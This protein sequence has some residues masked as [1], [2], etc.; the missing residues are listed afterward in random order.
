MRAII[1]ITLAAILSGCVG[2]VETV[3]APEHAGTSVEVPDAGP[4]TH[5]PCVCEVTWVLDVSGTWQESCLMV[6]P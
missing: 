6:C 1:L 3:D 5:P 4:D 2:T